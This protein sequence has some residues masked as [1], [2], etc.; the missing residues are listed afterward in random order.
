MSVDFLKLCASFQPDAKIKSKLNMPTFLVELT[1][2]TVLEEAFVLFPGTVSPQD[3]HPLIHPPI[4]GV[5]VNTRDPTGHSRQ[6]TVRQSMQISLTFL[7]TTRVRDQRCSP[8][9]MASER[10]HN[11]CFSGARPALQKITWIAI[12]PLEGLV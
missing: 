1:T 5:P 7:S 12:F 9:L 3:S 11:K 8:A 10:T 6:E 4:V 2:R